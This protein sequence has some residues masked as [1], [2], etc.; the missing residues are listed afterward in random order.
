MQKRLSL[1]FSFF[2]LLLTFLIACTPSPASPIGIVPTIPTIIIPTPPSCTT[3]QTEPTPGPDTPS[4]FPPE[5]ATDRV[6]GAENPIVT[7]TEYSDYQDLRSGLLAEVI[8]RLLEEHPRE[9]RVVSRIFPLM[10]VHDKAALA[11][12]A[13]EAAAEQGKFW[14]LH[15]L[16]YAQQES[17]V[18]LSVE[19]FEQWLTAQVSALGMNVDQFQADLKREDIVA[20]VKEAWEGG[21]KIQLPGTPLILINGQIYGGPRDYSSL[22]DIIELI[23]LGARQFKSCP[24]VTVQS[25]KQYIATLHTEKGDVTIQLFAD[26]APLT[27]NSF[28]FLARNDWYDNITFHRVVPD[29]FAQTGDPSGTGRGNPGYYIVTEIDSSLTF[30]KPGMVA[31]VNSGPDTSG[32]QFF[33]TYAPATQYNGQYTIFGQVLSGMEVLRNLTPRD[34]QPGTEPVPGDKLISV[35]VEEK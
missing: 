7:I 26:K 2:F 9:V 6:R 32:S 10:R 14:E 28:L 21:Q 24:P 17:W 25:N 27:V 30:D 22:K 11:A 29:L 15:H 8:D 18:N 35:T 4:L 19:D 12:Q 16:L 3:I 20:K 23:A 1:P 33:I 13:A 31:M 34:P 5:S